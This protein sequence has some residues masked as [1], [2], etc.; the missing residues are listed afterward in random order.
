MNKLLNPDEVRKW[1]RAF[2]RE[3][4][5]FEIRLLAGKND[6][7]YSGYFTD[8]ETAI[9]AVQ[10]FDMSMVYQIYFTVN[11]V[12]PACS[13]RKQ[14]NKFMVVSGSATSKNDISHRW[15]LPVDIDV[16]RPPPM[17]RNPMHTRRRVRYTTSSSNADSRIPLSA[18]LLLDITCTIL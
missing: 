18:T 4:E 2:K 11:E 3:G 9:Q 14:F 15:M 12:N 17:K 10:P 8:V 1:H 16:Q 13:S 6:K 5:L 7:T